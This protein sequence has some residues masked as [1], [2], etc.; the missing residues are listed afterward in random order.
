M[1]LRGMATSRRSLPKVV[2]G[3]PS[4]IRNPDASHQIERNQSASRPS[5]T[6]SSDADSSTVPATTLLLLRI[7]R[8]YEVI[9]CV[10][11]LKIAQ[12]NGQLLKL[13]HRL[14]I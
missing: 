13:T 7:Y 5:A 14:G 2:I 9:L 6:D 8:A 11:T 3:Q 12:V 1:K 10:G 4:L